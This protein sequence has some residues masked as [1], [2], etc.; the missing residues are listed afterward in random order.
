VNLYRKI[1]N[2][3]GTDV[4]VKT[5][6]GGVIYQ[7]SM[8]KLC[9]GGSV[10]ADMVTEMENKINNITNGPIAYLNYRKLGLFDIK[11]GNPEVNNIQQRIST[12]SQS[13][14]ILNFDS[15]PLWSL[16]KDAQY[17]AAVKGAIEHYINEKKSTK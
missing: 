15:V 10:T 13:P 7:L 11:G 4:S 17:S 2:I 14:A 5:N 9:Y 12:F 1:I 3:F 6:H 16:I 8:L